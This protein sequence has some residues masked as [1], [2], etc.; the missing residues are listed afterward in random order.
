MTIIKKHALILSVMV[1]SD[2]HLGCII[3]TEL[4]FYPIQDSGHCINPACF[5]SWCGA[6]S[7]GNTGLLASFDALS[8]LPGKHSLRTSLGTTEE[9]PKNAPAYTKKDS[10]IFSG[11]RQTCLKQALYS[12][13]NPAVSLYSL[14]ASFLTTSSQFHKNQA[15]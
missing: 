12:S 13:S 6:S 10:C 4:S 5:E 9:L 7:Q 1:I 15:A 11:L 8:L 3:A 2:S 14:G